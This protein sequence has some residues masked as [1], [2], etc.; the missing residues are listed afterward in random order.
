MSNTKIGRVVC[1]KNEGYPASLTI[2]EAYDCLPDE[3]AAKH[4]LIRVVDD[5]GEDYLY[6]ESYFLPVEA[7]AEAQ[8]KSITSA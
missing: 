6:P 7:A 3:E 1:V 8:R 4:V 2:D 5:T